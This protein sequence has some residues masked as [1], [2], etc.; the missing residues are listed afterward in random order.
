MILYTMH[1]IT[2]VVTVGLTQPEY[3]V[4]EGETVTV[5]A[6]LQSGQLGRDVTVF[7]TTSSELGMYECCHF[8]LRLFTRWFHFKLPQKQ[9]VDLG[10]KL[11][12]CILSTTFTTLDCN[13]FL[14]YIATTL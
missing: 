6:Q 2:T 11:K 10:V 13:K 1:N 3:L 7:F 4:T 8:I 12:V 14:S 5:C 9:P